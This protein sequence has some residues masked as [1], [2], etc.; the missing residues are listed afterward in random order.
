MK[1]RRKFRIRIIARFFRW[2][3]LRRK[4]TTILATREQWQ[5]YLDNQVYRA[6]HYYHQI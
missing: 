6:K 4:S 3:D 1:H 2:L 5:M